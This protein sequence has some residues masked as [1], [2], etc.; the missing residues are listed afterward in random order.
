MKR[1]KILVIILVVLAILFIYMIYWPNKAS[2]PEQNV[3]TVTEEGQVADQS[4]SDSEGGEILEMLARLKTAKMDTDFLNK[5][6]FKSLVDHSVE[7][8]EEP[9]GRVNPFAPL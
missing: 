6:E 5:K 8:I 2:S 1:L 9:V 3:V 7:L 4:S